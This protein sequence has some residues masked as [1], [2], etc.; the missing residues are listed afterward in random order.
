MSEERAIPRPGR[1]QHPIAGQRKPN[2]LVIWG[3]DIG[4]WN[5]SC[6]NRGMMGYRTPNID[7]IAKEGGIFTDYYGQQS[8]T[9][10]R[11]A[12]I[13]GQSP[14]RTGL[15]KVGL[16]GAKEGLSFE[17]PTLAQLL[18]PLG[19]ATGQFGKNHL[20][21]RNEHLPTV[22]GFDVFLGNL[23]HLNAE[24]EPEHPDYPKDPRFKAT[25]GPRG[26]LKCEATN[27]DDRTEDPRFG[28]VGKQKIEDTGPCTK[29]RME[30]VDDEFTD[31][32]I[33]FMTDAHGRNTPFFC[34]WNSTHMHVWT[35][36]TE[37]QQGVTGLG[38]Y[39]DG[40][41]VHD[42]Q[43]GRLLDKLDEL[44]IA[45]NTI[46][47]YS[48]DNGAEVFTWPDGGQTPFH[49]EKGSTWEGGFR[50]PS[51]VRWPGVVAPGSE[52]NAICAHE[53]WLP[54]LMAA[55]G[56]PDIKDKLIAGHEGFKVHVDGYDLTNYLAGQDENSP[57]REFFYITDDGDLG[58]LRFD[59]YK[60]IFMEQRSAGFGTWQDPFTVLRVPL[61]FNIRSDPFETGKHESGSWERWFAEHAFVIVPAM[62]IVQKFVETFVD[63]PPRFA[64]GTFTPA[65]ALK[66]L[67]PPAD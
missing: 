62:A 18:K 24:D 42:A 59:H 60:A 36:L 7:R 28:V 58:A 12:F 33:D 38:L 43:V 44:G 14:L 11:A 30:T 15:T 6:Y 57:R 47:L 61:V 52:F 48:T 22:H 8:C 64:P 25:F 4:F 21:D 31:A 55:V 20:G 67:T 1:P 51:L 5:L 35:R 3:D 27:H 17:D 29:K 41:L 26:V 32:A 54:T 53:D 10:G 39:P 66:K 23:Y 45:D 16:P 13:T 50:V 2:I 65:D 37:E 9:A 56:E 49:G 40:M 19:Y 34:W 63:F 46:V